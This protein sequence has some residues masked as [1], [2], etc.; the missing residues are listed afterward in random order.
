MDTATYTQYI[1]CIIVGYVKT[2]P[3]KDE[4]FNLVKIISASWYELARELDISTNYR[5]SLK[6]DGGLS[7]DTRLEKILEKWITSETKPVTWE[8]IINALESLER[9]DLVKKIKMYLTKPQKRVSSH[10][11]EL[12]V[13]VPSTK[14]KNSNSRLVSV[15][16]ITCM[17][18][19]MCYE[20]LIAPVLVFSKFDTS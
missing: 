5:D 4:V 18:V 2:Q 12:H 14:S 15:Y 9:I 10:D 1:F 11:E 19:S 3:K 6:Q 20:S 13:H 17:Q 7:D 16:L 8:V